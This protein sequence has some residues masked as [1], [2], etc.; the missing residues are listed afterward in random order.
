MPP[1]NPF[2]YGGAIEDPRYFVGRR[3]ELARIFDLGASLPR[4]AQH[5]NVTGPRRIGKSSLL[6]Q[7]QALARSRLPKAVR[8]VYLDG[9]RYTTPADFFQA[10]GRALGNNGPE[11]AQDIGSLL[12]E[13]RKDGKGLMLLL[14]EL[15]ALVK[16]GFSNPFFDRLRAWANNN[17]VAL[18]VATHKPVAELVQVQGLT[19][20]FFN[21]FSPLELDLF[22]EEEAKELLAKAAQAGLPFTDEEKARIKRWARQGHGYQPAKLQLMAREVF[23]A[24]ARSVVDWRAIEAKVEKTWALTHPQLPWWQRWWRRADVIV[25]TLGCWFLESALR[26]GPGEYSPTTAR[27]WGWLLLLALVLAALA[28]LWGH[29]PMFRELWPFVRGLFAR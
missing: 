6:K 9:Q 12:E 14:D 10:L 19:S 27:I 13:R 23:W 24:K 28:T 15:E 21:L 20:P 18:V 5:V 22:T 4:Q 1:D 25:K 11:E 29:G 17:L 7:V 2:F 16:H 3:E 8:V 26:R